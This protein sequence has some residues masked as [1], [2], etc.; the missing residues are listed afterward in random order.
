MIIARAK[1]PFVEN[2]NKFKTRPVVLL[3][4]KPLGRHKTVLVLYITSSLTEVLDTDVLIDDYKQANLEKISII[5]THRIITISSDD[6]LDQLG[7]LNQD[8][9]NKIKQSLR[10]ILSLE[11]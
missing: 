1:I 3:S 7:E 11:D 2:P 9:I 6:I 4:T 10:K 5:K 8:Q